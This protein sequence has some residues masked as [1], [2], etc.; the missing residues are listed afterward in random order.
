MRSKRFAGD[1]RDQALGGPNLPPRDRHFLPVWR[2]VRAASRL[3]H[4]SKPAWT[5]VATLDVPLSEV[6]SP[7]LAF[8]CSSI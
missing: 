6:D 4:H 7:A 8:Q 1:L 3:A 5:L 2:A